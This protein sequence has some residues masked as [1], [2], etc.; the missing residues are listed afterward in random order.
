MQTNKTTRTPLE[1][2]AAAISQALKPDKQIWVDQWAE[3]N[4]VLPPDVPEPGPYRNSRTPYL[5]DIQRT[6]SPGSRYRE[7][8]FQ[9]PHQIGG[10]VS[11]ENML[12]SW[13]CNAAGSIMVV[14]PTLDDAKQWELARF[15]PMRLST[16]ALRRRI[17]DSGT[18][19]SDNTK[20]RKKFPG[21]VMRM[22]GANRIGAVKSSTIRYLKFE[23]PD[24]YPQALKDQGDAVDL[25]KKRTTNF[26]NK[27]KIYG[28]GTPTVEGRSAIAKNFQRGDQRRWHLHCPDCGHA[29]HLRWSQ[30]RWDEAEPDTARYECEACFYKGTENDWKTPNYRARR[31]DMTEPDC[32]RDGLAYWEATATGEPGVASWHLNAL[33]AP[34]GWRPWPVLVREW[35][36]AQSDAEKLKVFINNNLG[37]TYNDTVR[38]EV[39]AEHLQQRAE[40]YDL[41]T[42]PAGGLVCVAGVDTQDNRLAVVIRVYGR[43]EESWGVWH[44][45][46][47]GTPSS[48]ETWEKLRELLSAPIKHASGQ[49]MRVD[50]A[51]IDSGGHFSEDVYAF[52]KTAA[53][54][55]KSWFAIKG[56]STYD[57]P[58]LGRPKTIEFTWRGKPVPSGGQIRLVG[59][60]AIKNLLAGRLE[61]QKPGAGYLHFPLGFEADYYKQLRSESRV[62]KKTSKGRLLVWDNEGRRNESWDCE[63]YAY[64]AY[65]YCM[66]GRHNEQVF[67]EREKLFAALPQ[68]DLFEISEPESEVKT[69]VSPR[70]I[71]QS[72]LARQHVPKPKRGFARRY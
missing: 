20:L 21:G 4:R 44:G 18:K 45:E 2:Y 42:C 24:E 61:L 30:L 29:Q 6:M 1:R 26:G 3:E 54:K 69:D 23:E 53:L 27:A 71:Q 62:W 43:G 65:L 8:W 7:G 9:K 22:V 49:I 28:D 5:I 63:V 48:P 59:T 41:M 38:S 15:E 39:V 36:A 25:I 12:G 10:S 55:G 33:G 14:F 60:Q 17:R 52:C 16:Q 50:A 31:A 46:I 67:R 40:Q 34:V 70:L 35:I 13:I 68:A 66:S 58:K 47:H 19:G 32:K 57:A 51:A 37:E 64:A 56:A 72:M 11:G